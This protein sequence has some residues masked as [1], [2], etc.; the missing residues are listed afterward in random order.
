MIRQ[1]A[2]DTET[3][4]IGH[5]QGHRLIELGCV[6]I[7]D[8]KLTGRHYHTYFNPE[9]KIDEGAFKVHGLSISFLQ[10]K[11]L[12]D[13]CIT[14]ILD[15]IDG[16][17]LIIH[18]APFDLGFLNAELARARIGKTIED[19]CTIL[20]TLVLSRQKNPGQ[21]HSLDALCKR[22]FIDNTKRTLHGALLDAQI[23]SH[24]YLAMTGGQSALSFEEST[25][26][27]QHASASVKKETLTSQ[28]PV[29]YAS[30]EEIKAHADFI[31]FLEKKSGMMWGGN[32]V[33]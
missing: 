1:I 12:F 6:E 18:N 21:R 3:T 16:A 4:G 7:I 29:Q 5:A 31:S 17:E 11:P 19:Y 13:D 2:L 14:S 15:F 20:D 23:L 32:A 24:V 33:V 25:P 9:R 30:A 28:S 26:S 8:R 10:D 27:P 22:Y